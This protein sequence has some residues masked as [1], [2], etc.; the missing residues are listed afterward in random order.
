M[1][2]TSPL[3]SQEHLERLEANDKY[4]FH[5]NHGRI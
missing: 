5:E 1:K 3:P 2:K 4:G